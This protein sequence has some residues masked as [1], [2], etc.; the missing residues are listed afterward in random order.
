MH[1]H[2]RGSHPVTHQSVRT[3]RDGTCVRDFV[4]ILDLADAHTRAVEHLLNN[5]TSQALNLGTSHGTTVKELLDAVRQFTGRSFNVRYGPRRE[6][7]SPALVADSALALRTI[8]WSPRYDLQSIIATA[9][10][11]HSNHLPA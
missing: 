9:W 7:D 11:W 8:G 3:K 5:G 10:N 6:G 1:T 2:G 4:H